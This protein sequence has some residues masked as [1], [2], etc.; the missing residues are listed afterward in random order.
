MLCR[1][2]AWL[3]SGSEPQY[4]FSGPKGGDW[5][6]ELRELCMAFP[7]VIMPAR[8]QVTV[9][10]AACQRANLRRDRMTKLLRSIQALLSSQAHYVHK[11]LKVTACCIPCCGLTRCD[12]F[13][14]LQGRA[15]R[16]PQG[17]GLLA[18]QEDRVSQP[19]PLGAA[20]PAADV[21]RRQQCR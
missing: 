14:E 11:A 2:S 3:W 20:T 6:L 18:S 7:E 1:I 19:R 4:A 21:A 5:R 10:C 12:G 13:A 16:R 8:C 9:A 15:D 17:D